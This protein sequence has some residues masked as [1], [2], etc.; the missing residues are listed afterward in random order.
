MEGEKND[1]PST[2]LCRQKIISYFKST[3]VQEMQKENVLHRQL[4][5]EIRPGAEVLSF[6]FVS[7]MNNAYRVYHLYTWIYG[8]KNQETFDLSK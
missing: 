7:L 3:F 2:F 4:T 8:V 5:N 1:F 6:Q